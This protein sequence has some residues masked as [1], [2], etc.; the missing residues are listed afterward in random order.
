MSKYKSFGA[1]LLALYILT[2]ILFIIITIISFK[3]YEIP[4]NDSLSTFIHKIYKIENFEYL[5]WNKN[6]FY[7]FIGITLLNLIFG[8]VHGIYIFSKRKEKSYTKKDE[9]D[10]LTTT[11][12]GYL[13]I[14]IANI[15][16]FVSLLCKINLD[17]NTLIV[18]T[19][20]YGLLM[21]IGV[22]LIS[23]GLSEVSEKDNKMK[24]LK[25]ASIVAP[26]LIGIT[27]I[28]YGI[29][30]ASCNL[31]DI[32]FRN[33]GNKETEFKELKSHLNNISAKMNKYSNQNSPEKILDHNLT[34]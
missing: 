15:I 4:T 13:F 33:I 20:I 25:S 30:R 1:S 11:F 32:D 12:V 23:I 27:G 7:L 17:K 19:F 18:I 9:K 21:I 31:I 26:S 10:V 14:T 2:F 28:M 24:S 8:L 29:S 5:F 22:I 34:K 6:M 16:L 3:L